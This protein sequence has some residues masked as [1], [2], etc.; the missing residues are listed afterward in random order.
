MFMMRCSRDRAE[1]IVG[2]LAG[3]EFWSAAIVSLLEEDIAKPLLLNRELVWLWDSIV[4]ADLWSFD[5][6]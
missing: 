4:E 1:L 3:A 6:L 5:W 2:G